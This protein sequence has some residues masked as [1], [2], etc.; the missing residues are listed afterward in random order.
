MEGYNIA[1]RVERLPISRVMWVWSTL[2]AL[3]MFWDSFQLFTSSS[4]ALHFFSIV[5]AKV[6]GAYLTAAFF[7]GTF[8]GAIFFAILGDRVGRRNVFAATLTIMGLGDLIAAFAN[9]GGLLFAGITIAGFGAG[10]Q[11][12]LNTTYAQELSPTSR[13]GKMSAYQLLLGF[14]GGTIGVLIA[15]YLVPATYVIPGYRILLLIMAIGAISSLLIRL[16]LPESPRWLERVGRTSDAD[17]VMTFIEKEVIRSNGLMKLPEP[18]VIEERKDHRHL[19]DVLFG[20][21]YRGRTA[22]AWII[23]FSQGFGFY[24]LVGLVPSFFFTLGYS[25]FKSILFTAIITLSYPIGVAISYPIIDRIQRRTGIIVFYFLNMLS[26]I[27]FVLSG[28]YHAPIA[29]IVLFAFL[30]ELLVFIDGPF[31]HTYEVE[32][33]PTYLRSSA[34]GISYSF[35]R[36][37][38]FVAPL[39]GAYI[40]LAVSFGYYLVFAL[41][42]LGWGICSLVGFLLT[43]KTTNTPLENLEA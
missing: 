2:L 27:A 28:L 18:I 35:D 22:G 34:G 12:P 8:S 29:V 30:T 13:R 9:S 15:A 39:A 42:A 4:I 5:N 41:G 16:K 31:I 1:S 11:I 33:Y 26:G 10:V 24:G 25:I 17:K 21:E 23:E 14:S 6:F 19:K 43:I 32:I 38:G 36:F 37:G 3:G 20:K 40:I 7:G